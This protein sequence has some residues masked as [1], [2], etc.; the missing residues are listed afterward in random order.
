MTNVRERKET[1]KKQN[2]TH[3]IIIFVLNAIAF[4]DDIEFFIN[5]NDIANERARKRKCSQQT[6]F[7]LGLTVH[8]NRLPFI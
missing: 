3:T 6:S 2:H 1:K 7:T 4:T 5:I 8:R